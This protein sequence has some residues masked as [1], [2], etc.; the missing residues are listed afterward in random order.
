MGRAR[1]LHH[2]ILQS[3]GHWCS[4]VVV[5]QRRFADH[6]A[7]HDQIASTP[8]SLEPVGPLGQRSTGDREIALDL[9]VGP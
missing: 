8:L 2:G 1:D 4:G 9:P 5:L 7:Y 6:G 3:I